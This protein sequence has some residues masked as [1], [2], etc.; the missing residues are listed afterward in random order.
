MASVERIQAETDEVQRDFKEAEKK[1]N[2][3]TQYVAAGVTALRGLLDTLGGATEQ[4]ICSGGQIGMALQAGSLAEAD[5]YEGLRKLREVTT[6]ATSDTAIMMVGA[7]AK[8]HSQIV[9]GQGRLEIVGEMFEDVGK[10]IK[11]LV[12]ALTNALAKLE[13]ESHDGQHT[14]EL[15]ESFTETND[16]IVKYTDNL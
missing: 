7:A 16:A 4:V 14:T 6:G 3:R 8:T 1:V 10:S 9:E 5:A 11:P 12:N 15:H 2:L 13:P